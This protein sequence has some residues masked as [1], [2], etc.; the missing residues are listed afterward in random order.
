MPNVHVF[1]VFHTKK[2][3]MSVILCIEHKTNNFVECNSFYPPFIT[4]VNYGSTFYN[5]LIVIT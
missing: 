3:P 4:I 2:G 1:K 5:M